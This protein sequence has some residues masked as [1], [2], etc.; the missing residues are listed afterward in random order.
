[1]LILGDFNGHLGFTGKQKLDNMGKMILEMMEKYSL[2]LLNGDDK[3]EGQTTWSRDKQKSAID[4]VLVNQGMYDNFRQMN[5]DEHKTEFDLSNH[6]LFS[7]AF[8]I[9]QV[10]RNVFTKEVKLTE[11]IKITEDAKQNF[12]NKLN[13]ELKDRD[14]QGNLDAL[15]AIIDTTVNR[16][17]K[18]TPK[19]RTDRNEPQKTERIW[20][21]RHIQKEISTRREYNKRKRKAKNEDE[22]A[23]YK[24]LYLQQS[25][26]LIQHAVEEHERKVTHEIMQNPN[27]NKK[28]LEKY[29]Q[30]KRRR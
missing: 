24:N 29:K 13:S 25:T 30:V 12:L 17:L 10:K 20:F 3:C 28:S 5:I 15:E 22:K 18:K 23:E 21:S 6:H 2:I 27:R 16:T 7:T 9:K 1:M 14:I 11:Y 19:K 26:K 4:F 8:D